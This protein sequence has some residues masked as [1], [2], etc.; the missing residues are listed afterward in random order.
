MERNEYPFTLSS[1]KKVAELSKAITA[2]SNRSGVVINVKATAKRK[3]IVRNNG[4]NMKP[5][6]DK[7]TDSYEH[8]Y[9]YKSKGKPIDPTTARLIISHEAMKDMLQ[10]LTSK[11]MIVVLSIATRVDTEYNIHITRNL[12]KEI[13]K[14]L[15]IAYNTFVANTSNLS[16]KDNSPLIRVA[17]NYYRIDNTYIKVKGANDK[18]RYGVKA[19]RKIIKKRTWFRS[20]INNLFNH[21]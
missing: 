11:E 5:I 12:R 10:R 2:I 14:E 16:N 9:H 3:P 21:E 17:R 1:A 4:D 8:R 18:T 19:K 7:S 6:V 20:L 13:S 15:G